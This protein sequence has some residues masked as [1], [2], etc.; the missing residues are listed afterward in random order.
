MHQF[1]LIC[2]SVIVLPSYKCVTILELYNNGTALLIF[3][4]LL[5]T[6]C[7]YMYYMMDLYTALHPEQGSFES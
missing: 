4:N 1:R 7:T 3:N 5:F 6:V 2:A